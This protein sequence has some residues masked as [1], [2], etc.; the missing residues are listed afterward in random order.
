M[1]LCEADAPSC[2]SIVMMRAAML[3]RLLLKSFSYI[4]GNFCIIFG[5]AFKNQHITICNVMSI[6]H[7]CQ[8][9]AIKKLE[10]FLLP[11]VKNSTN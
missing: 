5:N 2:L 7:A 6:R 11:S 8:K 4:V 1:R 9:S 3:D 10:T